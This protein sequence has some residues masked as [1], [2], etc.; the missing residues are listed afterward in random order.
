MGALGYIVEVEYIDGT[1]ETL[2]GDWRVRDGVLI[3]T[4]VGYRKDSTH[5]PLMQIKRYTSSEA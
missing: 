4:P 2:R 5:I 1:T 3:V